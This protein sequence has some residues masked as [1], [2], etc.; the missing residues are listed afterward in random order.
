MNLSETETLSYE[1]FDLSDLDR[2]ADVI[3]RAFANCDPMA[4]AQQLSVNELADYVKLIGEWAE[5][6]QLTVVAKHKLTDEV[7]GVVLAGDFALDFPLTPE[8]SKHLS[9]KFEPIVE[10]LESL[11]AQYKHNKQIK[12]GEYLYIHMLAV[13]PEHQR[14]KIAQNSI[15]VCLNNGIEKGFT[16]ALV[17]AANS[18]SQHIFG[19]LGFIPRHQIDYQQFT[20]QD[21]KVFASIKAHTGTILMDKLLS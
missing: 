12:A 21:K 10:V 2:V 16:S 6:Q 7:V 13:S 9:I 17:E 14:K 4:I 20:Y 18:V 5:K 15:Q 1:I 11:E 8:N 19:K 3:G